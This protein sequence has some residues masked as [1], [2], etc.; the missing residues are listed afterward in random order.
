M[1]SAG[2]RAS[3]DPP[4]RLGSAHVESHRRGRRSGVWSGRGSHGGWH[5]PPDGQ[6]RAGGAIADRR[7]PR[8]AG[9][10]HGRRRREHPAQ[11]APIGRRIRGRRGWR[12]GRGAPARLH[13]DPRRAPGAG[14]G[15]AR[16]AASVD[17][18]VRD[19]LLPGERDALGGGARRASVPARRR[20]RRA[21]TRPWSPCSARVDGASRPSAAAITTRCEARGTPPAPPR[22]RRGTRRDRRASRRR[23]RWAPAPPA[24]RGWL[25]RRRWRGSRATRF[26]GAR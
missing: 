6:R 20:I 25:P 24:A 21:S 15:R 14:C 8:V 18:A 9:R 7:S 22:P 13:G 26:A 2:S 1:P 12:S 3:F 10:L 4:C 11:E 23:D 5:G 17:R 19:D 16:G